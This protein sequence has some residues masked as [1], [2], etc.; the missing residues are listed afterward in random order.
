[1]LGFFNNCNILQLSHK[2][3]SSEEID[4]MHQVVLDVSSDN[5]AALVQIWKYGDINTIDTTT[6]G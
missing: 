5:M 6:V 2:K 1:M 3:T 4:R